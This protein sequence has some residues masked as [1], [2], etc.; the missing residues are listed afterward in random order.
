MKF[1]YG[2]KVSVMEGIFRRYNGIITGEAE[3]TSAY[4]GETCY[5]IRINLSFW[6]KIFG[7][8]LEIIQESFLELK[9]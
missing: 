7:G 3:V 1:R 6:D 4:C 2:D 8:Q 9:K 5:F